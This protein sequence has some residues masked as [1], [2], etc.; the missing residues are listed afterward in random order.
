MSHHKAQS[1]VLSNKGFSLPELL[2]TLGVFSIVA[3]IGIPNYRAAQPGLRLN[4][5]A[6]QVLSKLM[7]ARSQAVEENTTYVV[8]F[9]NNH[10]LKIFNDTNSNGTAEITEWTET[11]DLRVNYP[12]VSLSLSGSLPTFNGR[13]TTNGNTT[14]TFTNGS[15]SKILTMNPTGNV[16]IH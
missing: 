9:P 8:I 15:G 16:K 11:V 5:A 1:P 13:G 12:D 4:G 14:I 10:E 7:W 3:M 6:R 2:T